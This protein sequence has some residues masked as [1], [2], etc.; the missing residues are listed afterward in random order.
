MEMCLVPFKP[1]VIIVY[2]YTHD[3]MI[4]LVVL[5]IQKVI[6]GQPS[7]SSRAVQFDM[8]KGRLLLGYLNF[9]VA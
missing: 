7:Q 3:N 9:T 5:I 6:I 4:Y 1:H 8:V 2:L